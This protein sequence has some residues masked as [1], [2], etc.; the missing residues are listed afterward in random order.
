MA[1]LGEAGSIG[2]GTHGAVDPMQRENAEYISELV[3]Q[4]SGL[5]RKS[6]LPLLSYLLDVAASQAR[7]D[8]Q[9]VDDATRETE[10][11]PTIS[12]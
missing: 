6:G 12:L 5:A 1:S 2:G 10:R 3:Q 9:S 11:G 8:A 7:T 4:L